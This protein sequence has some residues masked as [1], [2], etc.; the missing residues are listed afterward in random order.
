MLKCVWKAHWFSS[1]YEIALQNL[2]RM[3]HTDTCRLYTSRK[4][5]FQLI[6]N[7][8]YTY[9]VKNESKLHITCNCS[10]E[11]LFRCIQIDPSYGYLEIAKCDGDVLW[12]SIAKRL[13]RERGRERELERNRGIPLWCFIL[14]S[15]C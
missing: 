10:I 12:L 8:H 6:W 11:Q 2:S 1:M 9:N 14:N 3:Q 13:G 7:E 5:T 15:F 4:L